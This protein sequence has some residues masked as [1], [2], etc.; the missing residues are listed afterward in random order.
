MSK[1]LQA[2]SA[3][4][5]LAAAAL[6]FAWPAFAAG[7]LP[8]EQASGDVR[9]VTG[10]VGSDESQAFLQH[11]RDYPLA[12]E[13]Y[14]RDGGREVYTADAFVQVADARGQTVLQASAQGPFMFVDLPPGRYTVE[15]MRQGRTQRQEAV[16]RA[17]QTSREI[18]VFEGTEP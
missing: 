11:R 15:V 16:V 18:F 12:V 4:A 9:Y 2:R 1:Q 8:P 14:A 17:G 10:G 13:I 5:V 7:G 6:S 3:A